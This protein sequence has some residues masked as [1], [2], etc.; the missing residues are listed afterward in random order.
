MTVEA[1][2]F[3]GLLKHLGEMVL[4]PPLPVSYPNAPF[5]PPASGKYLRASHLPNTTSAV[6]LGP[7]G[8]NRHQGLF[9]VMVVWPENL[10][11]IDAKVVAD[12]IVTRFKRGTTITH[13][14]QIIRIIQPPSVAP[15]MQDPPSY[16]VPVTIRYLADAAN[17]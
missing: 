5:T 10:G 8:I 3:G 13:N 4:T 16:M 7:N 11:E 14:G 17:P 1:N 12:A 9:Q 6:T 2:I 15:G